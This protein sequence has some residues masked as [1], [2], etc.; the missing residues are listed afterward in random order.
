M[1]KDVLHPGSHLC[2]RPIPPSLPAGAKG[3]VPSLVPGTSTGTNAPL[4][5]STLK[6]MKVCVLCDVFW[7]CVSVFVQVGVG[8][9]YIVGGCKWVGGWTGG[10]A[11]VK[12][13]VC[14][15]CVSSM[16][17]NCSCRA[18]LTQSSVVASPLRSGCTR[19]KL[20]SIRIM[21]QSTRIMLQSTYVLCYKAH[22]CVHANVPSLYFTL[23]SLQHKHPHVCVCVSRFF[24]CKGALKA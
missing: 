18:A 3:F 24:R 9:D 11:Y 16:C 13:V 22:V 12:S 19:I 21:L 1:F 20:Q 5:F 10:Y 6:T 4:G 2:E 14:C 7:V 17:M 8:V 15:V 23:S